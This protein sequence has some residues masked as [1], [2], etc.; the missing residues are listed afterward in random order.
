MQVEFEKRELVRTADKMVKFAR[1]HES[2]SV[3]SRIRITVDSGGAVFEQRGAA[4]YLQTK[5]P[6]RNKE[7][8][9]F[10][11]GSHMFWDIITTMGAD[12]ISL[13]INSENKLIIKGEN[14]SIDVPLYADDFSSFS[15]SENSAQ[16]KITLDK[17]ELASAIAKCIPFESRRDSISGVNFNLSASEG[18]IKTCC[19]TGF[20]ASIYTIRGVIAC[21]DS[22]FTLDA[23]IAK[24]IDSVLENKEIEMGIYNN[25]VQLTDGCSK[26]II[27]FLNTPFPRVERAIPTTFEKKLVFDSKKMTEVLALSDALLQEDIFYIEFDSGRLI[28]KCGNIVSETQIAQ[29]DNI[30]IK[31]NKNLLKKILY[32][33]GGDFDCFLY[34]PFPQP[35]VVKTQKQTLLIAP[36]NIK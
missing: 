24:C 10:I 36:Q 16:Q 19:M 25:F 22:F 4:F 32:A 12:S 11:V 20:C 6:C 33:A 13:A 34:N 7:N 23:S 2:N 27:Y 17:K 28:L 5:C 15:F 1:K 9:S 30:K 18:A 14:I 8:G 26:L 3:Y 29:K 35:L 31:L 21:E